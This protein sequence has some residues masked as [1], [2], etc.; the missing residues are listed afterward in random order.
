[1][2]KTQVAC[3]GAGPIGSSWAI[4][5]A[6]AGHNVRLYD[7]EEHV[8]KHSLAYIE[9]S[10]ADLRSEELVSDDHEIRARIQA[11]VSLA[12]AVQDAGVII[13]SITENVDLKRR[14]FSDL[15]KLIPRKAFVTSSTSAI[16]GSEFMDHV[17]M[18]D[19]CLIAHPVN[20]PHLLPV[21][22]I[23]RTPW[24]SQA[25]FT[26]CWLLMKQVGQYPIQVNK[27]IPAFVVNRLQGALI[28]EALHLVDEGVISVEDLDITVKYG[29]GRRL[30]FTGPFESM[31][32]NSNLSFDAYLTKYKDVLR[33]MIEATEVKHPLSKELLEK[34]ATERNR[35][36]PLEEIAERKAWRDRQLMKIAK[37]WAEAKK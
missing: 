19:R 27:E 26:A 2:T 7:K 34:V 10:L 17:K 18:R 6:R 4:V 24:T 30:A 8:F 5:F 20:P 25:T 11:G 33:T 37:L 29:I 15:D 35:L 9:R 22:E 1:M 14:F 12:D 31:H 28:G 36:L 23:C 21:V 13:E 16:P 3:I 32:L